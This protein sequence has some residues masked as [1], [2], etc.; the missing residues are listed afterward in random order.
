M[1]KYIITAFAL[2]LISLFPSNSQ[3]TYY[4]KLKRSI[5]EG[6]SSTEVK[7]G[8]FVSFIG[9]VC[10]ESDSQGKGVGHGS[11]Q[12]KDEYSK[13]GIL[14]YFGESYYG[15]GTSFRF[16]GD[17][18][19]LN[20]TTSSGDTY[21]YSQCSPPKGV[22]TCSLIRKPTTGGN[23]VLPYQDNSTYISPQ[24]NNCIPDNST[25]ESG[26]TLKTKEIRYK[27]KCHNCGGKGNTIYNTY[28][29]TFGLPSTNVWCSECGRYYSSDIGHSHV[30]CRYCHGTGEIEKVRYENVYE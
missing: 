15:K 24:Q 8:Q 6:V 11:L 23:T 5:I 26:K 17:K 16:N 14:F 13:N 9:N 18:T 28:P 12:R 2:F 1:N 10:Y 20:V 29:P 30:S 25:P 7:G 3:T 19:I 4:Y 21:V 27:E 22:T